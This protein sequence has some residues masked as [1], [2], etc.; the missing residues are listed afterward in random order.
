MQSTT[1][2]A[3]LT[4]KPSHEVESLSPEERLALPRGN[5]LDGHWGVTA[6]LRSLADGLND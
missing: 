6:T 3:Q 5:S 4:E 1:I 2:I